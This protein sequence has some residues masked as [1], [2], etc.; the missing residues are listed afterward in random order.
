[1]FPVVYTCREKKFSFYFMILSV[2]RL[3]S[4][5]MKQVR[6]YS[7]PQ[8]IQQKSCGNEELV[9]SAACSKTTH[10]I[11]NLP[12]NNKRKQKKI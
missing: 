12:A 1:M 3:Y 8:N 7:P 11:T 5:G 4:I 10:I 2:S 6:L 9:Q